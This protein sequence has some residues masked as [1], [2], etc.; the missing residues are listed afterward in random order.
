M[1]V[2]TGFSGDTG[3]V[4][5]VKVWG[6][7]GLVIRSFAEEQVLWRLWTAKGI[8]AGR[9]LQFEL[10]EVGGGLCGLR[11]RQQERRFGV[12]VGL[13]G[14]VGR[15]CS[16]GFGGSVCERKD[17]RP[18]YMAVGWASVIAGQLRVSGE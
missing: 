18:V 12:K 1:A 8:S 11:G 4:P 16:S 2:F 5:R 9:W 14:C 13:V 17:L 3:G 6:I 15:R 7:Q 10:K